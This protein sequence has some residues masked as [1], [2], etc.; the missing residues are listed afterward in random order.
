VIFEMGFF[1]A[2]LGRSRVDV[3]VDEHVERPSDIDGL[4]Y[5]PLDS[6]GGW[7]LALGKELSQAGI[8]V[9]YSKL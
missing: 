4:V 1:F 9:N 3:L 8:D 7:K 6:G 5:I 2:A